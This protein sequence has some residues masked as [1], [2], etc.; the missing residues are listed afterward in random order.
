MN[1]ES[2]FLSVLIEQLKKRYQIKDET[3]LYIYLQLKYRLWKINVSVYTWREARLFVDFLT[4]ELNLPKGESFVYK[5]E[6]M[7][8]AF[9]LENS[10][11]N[12]VE[13]WDFEQSLCQVVTETGKVYAVHDYIE[14][15]W[16]SL[17][18]QATN[19]A[20]PFKGHPSYPYYIIKYGLTILNEEFSPTITPPSRFPNV[21]YPADHDDFSRT[22]EEK[23]D[24]VIHA[25]E[26]FRIDTKTIQEKDVENFLRFHLDK[27]EKGLRYIA[28]Q[29][30]VPDG[31]IDILAKDRQGIYV[32][33]ELKT[34]EDRELVWQCMYYPYQI[35][36]IFSV[37]HVRMITVASHYSPALEI[38]LTQ[39]G[40]V[41]MMV[42]TPV[43]KQGKIVD[44]YIYPHSRS[45]LSSP[46]YA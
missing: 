27:I 30:P 17:H 3:R 40:Y 35:K 12:I 15:K 38:P 46:S 18:R 44:I 6:V 20:K 10:L 14:K 32:V 29:Y 21:K 42:F 4:E 36:S 22:I 26:W 23:V 37:P 39:L 28:H 7:T 25:E 33:I 34:K 9:A 16:E 45:F 13:T 2:D 19:K 43:V 24:A 41:E 1:Y 31:R 5:N 8:K 11:Q